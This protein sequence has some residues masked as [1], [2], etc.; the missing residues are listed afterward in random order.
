MRK[1]AEAAT[2]RKNGPTRLVGS[3]TRKSSPPAAAAPSSRH[4]AASAATTAL[5]LSSTATETL[6]ELVSRSFASVDGYELASAEKAAQRRAGIFIDGIQYGEIDVTSFS[7]VLRWMNPQPGEN[8]YD[9]GSGTGKAVITA[10]ALYPLGSATGIE[11]Q[12]ALHQAALRA[13]ANLEANLCC[14]SIATSTATSTATSIASRPHPSRRRQHSKR[15]EANREGSVSQAHVALRTPIDAVRFECADALEGS[16]VDDADLVFCTTTCFTE[17]MCEKL[18]AVAARLRCGARPVVAL[19]RARP[20]HA[21][22]DARGHFARRAR[23]G[24][25]GG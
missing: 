13:K 19:R 23:G 25:R 24:A 2:R 8:F 22:G 12:P 17:D 21:L 4:P 3:I 6:I 10:A 9:L 16:W 20:C 18:A 5:P 14:G 11:I 1:R 7:H 15:S